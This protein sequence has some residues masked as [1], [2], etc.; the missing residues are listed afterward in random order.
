LVIDYN[1]EQYYTVI[2]LDDFYKDVNEMAWFFYGNGD[3][4]KSERFFRE[5]TEKVLQSL[6]HWPY[7]NKQWREDEDEQIRRID[8]PNHKVALVY[9]VYDNELEVIALASFHTLQDPE[10]YTKLVKERLRVADE[11]RNSGHII[12]DIIEDDL[13]AQKQPT[14]VFGA[15]TDEILKDVHSRP[16]N[17]QPTPPPTLN[18]DNTRGFTR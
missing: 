9:R 10:K 5:S 14:S 3:G 2:A 11:R 1:E 18:N 8:M 4:D 13:I 12:E 6:T 7:I 16:T 17:D 15:G